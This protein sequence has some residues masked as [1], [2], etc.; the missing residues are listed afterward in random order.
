M[1]EKKWFFDAVVLSN[2]LFA[3]AILLLKERYRNCGIITREVYGE[4]SAGFA[5]YPKLKNIDT[6]L[7]DKAFRLATLSKKT[8]RFY[9]ELI[10][11]FFLKSL[12]KK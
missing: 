6:L 11:L 1:P 10:L 3:D 12:V 9:L 7:G 5:E 4:I 8:R 2:F